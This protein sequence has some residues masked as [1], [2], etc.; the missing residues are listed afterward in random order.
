MMLL[1]LHTYI[2][3]HIHSYITLVLDFASDLYNNND[4]LL[5]VGFK[6]MRVATS[7]IEIHIHFMSIA[8]TNVDACGREVC[9]LTVI[10]TV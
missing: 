6:T 2:H 10:A 4:N 9:C 7:Y 8:E 5:I 1:Y 3:T